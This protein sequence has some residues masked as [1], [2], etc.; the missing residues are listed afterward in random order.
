MVDLVLSL[1]AG[2]YRGRIVALSRRGLIPRSPRGFR[3]GASRAR[4]SAP[5]RAVRG[6]WRWLRGE[7][8]RSRVARRHRQPAPAQPV[9]WQGLERRAAASVPAPCPALVGRAS[10]SNR[11]G[12]GADAGA[13]HR[14]GAA[15]DGCRADHL[16]ARGRATSWRSKSA[17]A[18]R[19]LQTIAWLTPSIALVRCTPSGAPAIR[20]CEACSMRPDAS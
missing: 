5:G 4:G 20:F 13:A 16:R 6:L 12:G 17:S 3:A 7:K 1:D 18:D 8:R 10:P 14:R 11:T 9:L 2:G 15:R 19:R